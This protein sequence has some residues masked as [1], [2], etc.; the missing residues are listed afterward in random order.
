MASRN[1][2]LRTL[3]MS[4]RYSDQRRKSRRT[5][6]PRRPTS[7]RYVFRF[8]DLC[9]CIVLTL[10]QLK[11]QFKVFEALKNASGFGWDPHTKTVTAPDDVWQKYIKSHPKARQFR[12]VPF[13][14]Y[15][16]LY[17]LCAGVIANGGASFNAAR[18]RR[19]ESSESDPA[20]SSEA[21]PG[22]L[23]K[24]DSPAPSWE[25]SE[26]PAPKRPKQAGTNPAR[27]S[28]TAKASSIA[29][30]SSSVVEDD[31]MQGRGK[32]DPP[33]RRRPT[34]MGTFTD[35]TGVLQKIVSRIDEPAPPAYAIPAPTA[36]T[37][38]LE[39]IL[40]QAIRS[41]QDDSSNIALED[42]PVVIDMFIAD[43]KAA[44]AWLAMK[45]GIVRDIWIQNRIAAR[46][47]IQPGLC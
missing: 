32:S 28:I 11:G 5:G 6:D 19:S 9:H 38:Q 8:V 46:R 7:Q 13:P 39:D 1:R 23:T 24:E 42:Q 17:T 36:P 30:K 3:P 20:D 47:C 43:T 27:S 25:G 15:D 33:K 35:I 14:L 31:G 12:D 40:A 44:T 37:L 34:Q 21:E 41:V 4:W 45:L 29:M 16:D 2:F 10:L 22:F 26:S 18:H